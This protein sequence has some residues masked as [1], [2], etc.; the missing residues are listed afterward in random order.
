MKI[1][2]ITDHRKSYQCA[3]F[4][5]DYLNDLLFY[6]LTELDDVEVVSST[7]IIHLYR[8]LQKHIDPKILWGNGFSASFLLNDPPPAIDTSINQKIH[9]RYFDYIVYG[10][11]YRCLDGYE[12]ISQ[13]YH[14]SRIILI[15]GE[16]HTNIHPLSEYHRYFKRELLDSYS[17]IIPIHFAIP[18]Q[19]ISSNSLDKIQ[20]LGTVIPGKSSTYI[21]KDEASYYN[22]YN[23]SYFGLTQKKAGWD[24]MRH[25]EILANC[26]VPLFI[27]IELCPKKIMTNMPK[28]LL[29]EAGQSLTSINKYASIQKELYDYTIKYLTTKKLAEYVIS[30]WV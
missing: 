10:S 24:C 20:M 23:I 3:G 16:D 22:D 25:Y 21:F 28:S 12:E 29:I 4:I 2:Y 27:D 14:K 11:V 18:S 5:N 15:D 9:D 1:L 26:C 8:P 30:F 13:I 7:P 6:G 19:K 17:G